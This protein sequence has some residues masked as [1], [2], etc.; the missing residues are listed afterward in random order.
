VSHLKLSSQAAVIDAHAL[1]DF[2]EI[3]QG[4]GANNPLYG[5]FNGSHDVHAVAQA[6]G[7][8]G[9]GTIRVQSVD[10][11]GIQIPQFALEWFVQHYLTP[12]YPNVGITSTFKLPLRIESAAVETAKVRLVQR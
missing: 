10:F 12:K 1:V 5:L 4:R 6:T 2:E 9:I 11:D 8:N 3:M 7:A